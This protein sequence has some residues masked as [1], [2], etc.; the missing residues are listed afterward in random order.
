MKFHTYTVAGQAPL[1]TYFT[2]KEA[3]LWD[4][5][6]LDDLTANA[7]E[8][9]FINAHVQATEM[10]RLRT[11]DF[12]ALFGDNTTLIVRCNGAVW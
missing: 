12:N 4:L 11:T 8:F 3:V 6:D 5:A 7:S 2:V 9:N 1:Q 10:N